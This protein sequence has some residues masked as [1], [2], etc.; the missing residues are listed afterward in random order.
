MF[1]CIAYWVIS[2]EIQVISHTADQARVSGLSLPA[3]KA[4]HLY[5]AETAG[6]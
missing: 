1:H 2:S 5:K 6:M 4:H 3:A